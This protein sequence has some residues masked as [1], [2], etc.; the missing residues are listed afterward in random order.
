[1]T[2]ANDKTK[3][4]AGVAIA[5]LLL[6]GGGIM[7]GRSVFAPEDISSAPISSSNSPS[8]ASSGLSAASTSLDREGS[9]IWLA[10]FYQADTNFM[11]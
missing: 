1:M 8:L 2:E 10:I 5:A 3:L 4:I 9:V 6:G 11:I 7:L